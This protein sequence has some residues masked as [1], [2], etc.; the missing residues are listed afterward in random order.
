MTVALF[1]ESS[2]VAIGEIFGPPCGLACGVAR[3]AGDVR[4]GY[5]RYFVK[6]YSN[7]IAF[8]SCNFGLE[9]VAFIVRKVLS[10]DGKCNRLANGLGYSTTFSFESRSE[11]TFHHL[12]FKRFLESLTTS[13][14]LRSLRHSYSKVCTVK[15][16]RCRRLSE[17]LR[18][19]KSKVV[20]AYYFHGHAR[21][22]GV[23]THY[24]KEHSQ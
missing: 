21:V 22:S 15:G 10:S 8:E 13:N 4:V 23:S 11:R 2:H 5:S 6:F 19:S 9:K 3:P 14:I 24:V 20:S 12:S 1:S 17:L 7:T 16:I 18:R